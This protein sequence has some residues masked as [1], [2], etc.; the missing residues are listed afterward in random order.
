M[1]TICKPFT[2]GIKA[3]ENNVN[4]YTP[5]I[6]PDENNVKTYKPDI[7]PH[8]NN[9]VRH[10]NLTHC[11]HLVLCQVYMCSHCFHLLLCQM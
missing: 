1:K 9:G 5:D 4:T 3:D 7:K 2:S 10:I 8:E 6:K 11:F